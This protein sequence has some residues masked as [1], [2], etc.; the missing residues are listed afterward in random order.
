MKRGLLAYADLLE[1]QSIITSMG[2]WAVYKGPPQMDVVA[3]GVGIHYKGCSSTEYIIT[4]TAMARDP[5][6]QFIAGHGVLFFA[7]FAPYP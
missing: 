4:A 7:P 3:V 1:L 2:P 5:K 6:T